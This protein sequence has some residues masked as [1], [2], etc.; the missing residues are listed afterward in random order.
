ML[1]E[2]AARIYNHPIVTRRWNKLNRY[3]NISRYAK[4][5]IVTTISERKI[6]VNNTTAVFDLATKEEYTE[7]FPNY[8]DERE[9][10]RD[11]LNIL[12]PTDVFY[13][14][15]ANIGL[16]STIVGKNINQRNVFSFEPQQNNYDKLKLN[17]ERNGIN[18]NT[19]KIAL[20]D[21]TEVKSMLVESGTTGEGHGSLTSSRGVNKAEIEVQTVRGD[22][23]ADEN[24]DPDLVKIDVEGAELKV[25]KGMEKTLNKKD[26]KLIYCEIHS[27]ELESK[28][29]N[30]LSNLG[31]NS[32]IQEI[33]GKSYVK[34]SKFELL[35][36]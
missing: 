24:K 10:L 6:K 30:Y 1:P 35:N 11:F 32:T 7:L 13:D 16:Y 23:F 12:E 19:S 9:I 21:E 5:I 26:I 27:K 3:T 33:C 29:Q 15:G 18:A 8:R 36:I 31:Y 2:L 17:L 34:A 20:S 22:D 28:V 14:V 4:K 25:L